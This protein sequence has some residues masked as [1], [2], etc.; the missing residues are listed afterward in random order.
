MIF[1]SIS[2]DLQA[3]IDDVPWFGG[4]DDEG[5]QA[6][7]ALGG[8]RLYTDQSLSDVRNL[9]VYGAYFHFE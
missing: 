8:R 4:Y 7:A 6:R 2:E 9:G 1:I 3:S 5:Q